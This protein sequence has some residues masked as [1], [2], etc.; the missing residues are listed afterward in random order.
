MTTKINLTNCT[1]SNEAVDMRVRV[2]YPGRVRGLL[3]NPH[4]IA[5]EAG[6]RGIENEE[7][8]SQIASDIANEIFPLYCVY[9]AA[10]TD[11]ENGGDGK[12]MYQVKNKIDRAC[13]L[14][15]DRWNKVL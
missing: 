6:F 4:A 10:V 8:K 9:I 14:I 7:I 5:E 3:I 1:I 2:V 13:I 11:W 12:T 15:Q